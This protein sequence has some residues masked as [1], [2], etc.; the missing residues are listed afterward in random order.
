LCFP[1]Q[2]TNFAQSR[3]PDSEP[4][5]THL[6][7]SFSTET[8]HNKK[9][10][11]HET[12]EV[13]EC[14]CNSLSRSPVVISAYFGWLTGVNQSITIAMSGVKRPRG[15]FRTSDHCSSFGTYSQKVHTS[16]VRFADW[17]FQGNTVNLGR[18]YS[19]LVQKLNNNSLL[20]VHG[21]WQN[22]ARTF[23]SGQEKR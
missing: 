4:D 20:T 7:R 14:F 13:F 21:K 6:L 2:A 8:Q 23:R 1:W 3:A 15:N 22:V 17:S 9:R 18:M 11:I 16:V 10:Y 19:R 5:H 12:P